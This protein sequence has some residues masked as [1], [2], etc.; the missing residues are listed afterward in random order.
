M[1]GTVLIV[2]VSIRHSTI[3][4][5]IEPA[6]WASLSSFAP[7]YRL[8]SLGEAPF[9]SKL[10]RKSEVNCRFVTVIAGKF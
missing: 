7:L 5:E 9:K 2:G 10:M 4:S 3:F 6:P 1:Y 8:R